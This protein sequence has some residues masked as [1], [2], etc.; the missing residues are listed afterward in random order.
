MD[1]MSR[2]E[3]EREDFVDEATIKGFVG[4]VEPGDEVS[5]TTVLWSVALSLAL[6]IG[7]SVW[8]TLTH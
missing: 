6:L 8:W 7:C 2:S 4:R 5:L 1:G 3:R